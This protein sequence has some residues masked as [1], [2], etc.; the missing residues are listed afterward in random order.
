MEEDFDLENPLIQSQPSDSIPSLIFASESY[1][2]P[3]QA[4]SLA[5]KASPA[6]ASLR[7]DVL[8]SIFLRQ[9]QLSCDPFVA[10]LA[11][12]Y[13]DRFLSVQGLPK[14]K[15]WVVK[16]LSISCISLALK[17][18]KIAFS[19]TD[20][21]GEE[22]FIFDTGTIRR[23]EL[24]ILSALQ[25]RMRSITPFAFL[26]FFLSFFERNDPPLK[27]ALKARAVE[28]VFKAQNEIKILEYKPSIIAASAL[29]SASHE[30]S[31]LQFPSFRK[32]ISSSVYI[33]KEKL[34]DCYNLMQDMVMDGYGLILFDG[35]S[36]TDTPVN[37]LDCHCL[38]SESEKTSNS[39]SS[40]KR[41]KIGDFETF[42][43]ISQIQHC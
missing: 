21:Q 39:S 6:N 11:V 16:L 33:N 29:L 26:G 27:E 31:P 17:M 2:T 40:G 38:S 43:Q 32:A 37:V 14:A 22:G 30:L 4:Y 24:L 35:V 18:K 15:P 8:S 3:S 42:H 7:R 12:N 28:I 34:L 13:L 23:M 19:V 20:F 10:Y 5:F 36:S 1:H 25:W 41:R 9:S